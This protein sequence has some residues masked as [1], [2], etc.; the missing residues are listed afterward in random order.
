MRVVK[1]QELEGDDPYG[2]KAKI[3]KYALLSIIMKRNTLQN[4][5]ANQFFASQTFNLSRKEIILLYRWRNS[6]F[7]S[8]AFG[9]PTIIVFVGFMILHQIQWNICDSPEN[10]DQLANPTEVTS[11]LPNMSSATNAASS[12]ITQTAISLFSMT[13]SSTITM[14]MM[15]TSTSQMGSVKLTMGSSQM[16]QEEFCLILPGLNLLNLLGFLLSTPVQ[17]RFEISD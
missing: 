8:L 11:L 4:K 15:M 9:T 17:V 10:P 3:R 6:F 7:I 1:A 2:Y 14:T 5:L 13:N 12:E 16:T